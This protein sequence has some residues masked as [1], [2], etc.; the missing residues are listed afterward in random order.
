MV[1]LSFATPTQWNLVTPSVYRIMPSEYVNEFFETGRLR[2]SSFKQFAS[3]ADEERGDTKEGLHVQVGVGNETTMLTATAHGS[4]AYILCGTCDADDGLFVR[5]G[6]NSAIVIK[7][8]TQFGYEISRQLAGFSGGLEGFCIYKDGPIETDIGGFNLESLKS[9]P[10]QSAF[11]LRKLG[12]FVRSMAGAEVFLRKRASYQH[13]REYRLAW[14]L[15]SM[16]SDSIFV[17][18]PSAIKFCEKRMI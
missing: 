11:D 4:N 8:T 9:D 16:A 2:L 13:Q 10:S 15:D 12:E 6:S 1:N 7:N 18:A 3:H 14:L 17:N 5:F